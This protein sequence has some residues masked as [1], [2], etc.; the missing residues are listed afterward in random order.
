MLAPFWQGEQFSKP[1]RNGARGWGC[2]PAG[3]GI[4]LGG[5]ALEKDGLHVIAHVLALLAEVWQCCLSALPSR[6]DP[7][8]PSTATGP[9]W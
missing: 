6:A 3:G 2:L 1:R 8:Q 9:A 4:V 5:I 7:A